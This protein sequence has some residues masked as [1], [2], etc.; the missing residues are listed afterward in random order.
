MEKIISQLFGARDTAHVF[1]LRT[2]SFS[3]HMAL[4]ELYDALV[5]LA[6]LLSEI[7]Q[8]KY[9]MLE[10]SSPEFIF[11]T[12][13]VKAFIV[14]LAVWAEESRSEINPQDTFILNEWDS[15]LTIIFRT[16]YKLERFTKP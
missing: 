5:D 16:K 1:H 11:S 12:D 6:D 4:G 7:Y 8:G 14:E 2:D 13:D 15:V 3:Q 10:L 9:G